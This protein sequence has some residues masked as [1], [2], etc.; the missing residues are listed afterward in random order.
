[1]EF[2][3]GALADAVPHVSSYMTLSNRYG[4]IF[5]ADP[6]GI[7]CTVCLLT[8]IPPTQTEG[9]AFARTAD[10]LSRMQQHQEDELSP[11]ANV[12]K[13]EIRDLDEPKFTQ[14]CMKV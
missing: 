14:V 2:K 3:Q 8:H 1:M 10:V 13:L 11:M 12:S 4:L 6:R 5:I 7:M 9:F